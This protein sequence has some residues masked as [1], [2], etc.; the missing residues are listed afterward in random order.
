MF[1]FLHLILAFTP[2]HLLPSINAFTLQRTS[3]LTPRHDSHKITITQ[4]GDVTLVNYI[5]GRNKE[6]RDSYAITS[7]TRNLINV[8]QI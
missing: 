5:Y 8:N 2:S 1:E 3:S 6:V 7:T 4:G